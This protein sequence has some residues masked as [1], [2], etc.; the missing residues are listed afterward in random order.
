MTKRSVDE[1]LTAELKTL[2]E[3]ALPGMEV[4]VGRNPRWE[5]RCVTFRWDGFA[6][7]L[8]EERF[9]RLVQVMPEEWRLSRLNG[10]VWLELAPAE[11]VD[12]YLRFP[13]SEDVA[14]RESLIYQNLLKLNFFAALGTTMGVTPETACSGDFAKSVEMLSKKRC[15]AET[16]RDA[17]LVMIRNGAY[18]DCQALQ[19]AQPAL[20]KL[21]A[22]AA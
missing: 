10:C 20:A 18:C 17:K 11:T 6:G 1:K 16:I 19:T 21:H 15:S 3:V 13:R 22:G 7:L 12:E 5:R 9:Y 8:P 2:V 4:E 14:E